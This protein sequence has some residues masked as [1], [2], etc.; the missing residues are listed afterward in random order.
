MVLL[1]HIIIAIT[2]IVYTTYL[3]FRPSNKGLS[4]SYSLLAL[5]IAS[6]T[7][8]VFLN[9]TIMAHAC[10]SGLV[11]TTVVFSLIVFAKR[12]LVSQEL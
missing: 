7:G 3:V 10:M 5:T 6:G 2:G 12:K 1:L 4:V 11:Y 9:P 8:L